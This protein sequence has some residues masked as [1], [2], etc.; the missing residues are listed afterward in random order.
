M[1]KATLDQLCTNNS[2]SSMSLKRRVGYQENDVEG[3]MSTQ[4]KRL[5]MDGVEEMDVT[6][7]E[8]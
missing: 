8:M 7:Q 3:S 1:T 5:R 6:E 4:M 2:S